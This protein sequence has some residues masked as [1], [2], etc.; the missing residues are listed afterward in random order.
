MK[1][2]NS[3]LLTCSFLYK[4]EERF[5]FQDGGAQRRPQRVNADNDEEEAAAQAE[6]IREQQEQ[7][8]DQ[9]QQNLQTRVNRA[10]N[11]SDRT[12]TR[13]RELLAS[14]DIENE[15][16]V[17][18]FLRTG[19]SEDTFREEAERLNRDNVLW[20]RIFETQR[21]IRTR[22]QELQYRAETYTEMVPRGREQFDDMM[23]QIRRLNRDDDGTDRRLKRT[24]F[25]LINGNAAQRIPAG[26]L[27]QR[28]ANLIY[29]MNPTQ[30]DI[31]QEMGKY[32]NTI[33]QGV[34]D[35]G[36][37][38]FRQLLD[39][40][41]QEA[42]AEV[43][44]TRLTNQLNT[45]ISS[46]L[47][48]VRNAAEKKRYLETASENI[49]ITLAPGTVI[50]FE[51]A[52]ILNVEGNTVT[53]NE[54]VWEDI[55][56]T[57]KGKVIDKIPGTARIRLSNGAPPMP[58]GR[59][60]KWVDAANGVERISN[61]SNVH[62]VLGLKPYGI[63]IETG[64]DISYRSREVNA[65][66]E[67]C[68][69]YNTVSI[70]EMRDG[71]IYFSQPILFQPGLDNVTPQE[72]RSSLTLGEFVKW[73][74]RYQ[75]EKSIGLDELRKHLL[76][77]NEIENHLWGINASDNP[78]IL[79]NE[80]ELLAFPDEEASEYKIER[81]EPDGVV[82]DVG[83][84]SFPQFFAWIK[85]NH[86]RRAK[87]KKLSAQQIA[88]EKQNKET[89]QL[90]KS[91][92]EEV[93]KL[94]E[95][96]GR[97]QMQE[98]ELGIKQKEAGGPIDMIK[99][100]W[101]NTEFLTVVDIKNMITQIVEFVKRKHERRSKARYGEAG[102]RLPWVLGTEFERIKQEA[103][104]GEVNKYKESMSNWGIPEIEETLHNTYTKDEAK[105]CIITLVS[106]GVMRWDD[107]LFWRTLNR[108]TARYTLD[109]AKLNIPTVIPWGESGE[110][111]ARTAIDKLWGENGAAEWIAENTSKYN[112]QKDHFEYTFNQLENDPK[113]IGGPRGY[114]KQLLTKWK[115]G[116]Y[117]NPQEYEEMIDASIK[118][119]KMYG[120]DKMFYL[121]AGC[122]A[123]KGNDPNGQTLLH[124]DR[125]GELNTKY[126][127]A[128]PLLDFFTQTMIMDYSIFDKDA[129]PPSYGKERKFKLSDYE[130]WAHTYFP[131]DYE[132]NRPSFQFNRFLW[133]KMLTNEEVRTRVSKGL[134]N[135]QD[136]DH[137]D[138]HL[139]IPL[140]SP[141]EID[142][143]TGNTTGQ[144]KFFTNSGYANGLVGFGNWIMTL[145]YAIR[146][147]EDPK[148]KTTKIMALRDALNAFIRYDLILDYRLL[149]H[150][151][152]DQARLDSRHYDRPSVVD[153][154]ET[155][156]HQQQMRN[157][158]LEVG[159][160]YGLDL[161]F[162]Y[163]DK[164]KPNEEA[165]QKE[166]ENKVDQMKGE[167]ERV[168]L[169][170][171][172]KK[173]LDVIQGI[174]NRGKDVPNGLRGIPRAARPP[175]EELA[176]LQSTR[177][178][179]LRAKSG[180]GGRRGAVPEP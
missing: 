24:L 173:A 147:A 2:I 31:R 137:D 124:L 176:K 128:Y 53:I 144:K 34:G 146:E 125:V 104:D 66:G 112:S 52:D 28:E 129:K 122:I 93:K 12:K 133:E 150:K 152:E 86:V 63:E 140:A 178:A 7:A 130:E 172:G 64:M 35:Q 177:R 11:A 1:P 138:A 90:N 179:Y 167:I 14:G 127:N 55:E 57:D 9:R 67:L 165:R 74:R 76:K 156:F 96:A 43:D 48:N 158:I 45:M 83:K 40:K 98:S 39:L 168:I 97:V 85:H 61:L 119:G 118:K 21:S 100:L 155:G 145:N 102:G 59:F 20:R 19:E 49:G 72:M 15:N 131:E 126:L 70:T 58:I 13:M 121:I 170:D 3:F 101:F 92:D 95:H 17:E 23:E 141:N 33:L 163:G 54:I 142:Q 115:A 22:I 108:L 56:I 32:R 84:M 136:I 132:N 51:D 154:V 114:L 113:G 134:R 6:R 159:R 18:R 123:R 110:D 30:V 68:S 111:M 44:M 8:R 169:S 25:D 153:D 135:A 27:S 151:K 166:Y 82:L 36:Q 41:R 99:N 89:M 65:N 4:E 106:K 87:P 79:V 117:V 37:V 81:L 157:L 116:D 46:R 120:E 148:D 91:H 42:R 174:I 107:P 50:E 62:S 75:A 180:V 78:P 47:I 77:Y 69:R 164:T 171:D 10:T 5:V 161:N 162:L 139:I 16:L 160:V 105:A 109:G 80:N 88:E 38:L 94:Q 73:W 26:V 71:K 60:K 149:K 143:L 29:S 103:E 175:A